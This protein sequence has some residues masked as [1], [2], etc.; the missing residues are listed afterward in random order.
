MIVGIGI[1]IVEIDRMAAALQRE[2]F[3]KRVFSEEEQ[4]YCEGRG[5]QRAASYAARFAAKEAAVKALGT[6]FSGGCWKD[7]SVTQDGNGQPYLRLQG[8][9]ASVA[10]VRGVTRMYL[11]LT[12]AREYAAA[13]V[14]MWGE[15][16]EAGNGCTN[17]SD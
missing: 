14:V 4:N 15:E 2:A 5:G 6:G 9:Y 13:Q 8:H 17:E 7:V 10:R 12:H 16:N 1:D 3:I 11:S